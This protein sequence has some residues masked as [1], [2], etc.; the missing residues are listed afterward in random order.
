MYQENTR[1]FIGNIY[2]A[3]PLPDLKEIFSKAGTIEK[4]DLFTDESGKSRG[5]GIIV[6]S[7]RAEALQAITIFNNSELHSRLI[8]VKEDE[9]FYI[10]QKPAQVTIKGMPMTVTWQ[11]LKDVCREMG[12]VLRADVKI[13]TNRTAT[14]TVLFDN[15]SQAAK[16]VELLNGAFFNG[17][18]VEAFCEI[19]N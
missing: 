17:M 19:D 2:Y 4:I 14:G 16:A 13:S 11:Q 3:I 8:T 9:T 6:Y 12:E 7:S 15:N 1:V 5:C 10:Q 18:K